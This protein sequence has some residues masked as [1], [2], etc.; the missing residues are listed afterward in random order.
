M[1]GS[2]RVSFT[3]HRSVNGSRLLTKEKNK[4]WTF[5]GNSNFPVRRMWDLRHGKIDESGANY[6]PHDFPVLSKGQTKAEQEFG[7]GV[8]SIAIT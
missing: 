5:P 3:P 6:Q 7:V 8:R 1:K 2:K 4:L